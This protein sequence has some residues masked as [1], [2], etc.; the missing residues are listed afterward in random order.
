MFINLILTWAQHLGS[1]VAGTVEFQHVTNRVKYTVLFLLRKPRILLITRS[2]IY[3]S[4]YIFLRSDLFKKK[5]LNRYLDNEV[6]SNKSV[7]AGA[8][9]KKN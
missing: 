8:G 9:R 5:I 6:S 1:I 7:T 3:D 4:T 2:C